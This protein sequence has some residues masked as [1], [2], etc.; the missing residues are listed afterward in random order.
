MN[1]AND[2]LRQ[3]NCS[4]EFYKYNFGMI[5][6]EG[7]KA[8]ADNFGLYWLLDI[9]ASYQPRL[10]RQEFQVW[11]LKRFE[12]NSAM[13][14]CTDGNDRILA[15]QEIPYTDFKC[16]LAILW[17]ECNVILLPSEH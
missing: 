14:V 17:V 5:I 11:K 1:N 2:T 10:R 15:Q 4:D 6:T 12:D 7:A 3:Y 13:V 8:L 16:C 9:V